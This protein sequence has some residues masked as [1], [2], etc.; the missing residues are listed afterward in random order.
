M[1]PRSVWQSHA[2]GGQEIYYCVKTIYVRTSCSLESKEQ[3]GTCGGMISYQN[4]TTCTPTHACSG[5]SSSKVHD[6]ACRLL[7]NLCFTQMLNTQNV[8]LRFKYQQHV[9]PRASTTEDGF[10]LQGSVVIFRIASSKETQ[11][12]FGTIVAMPVSLSYF[13]GQCKVGERQGFP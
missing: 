9:T 11:N 6:E 12:L 10:D 8:I 7:H 1:P 5:C 4:R 13:I 2:E 3:Q